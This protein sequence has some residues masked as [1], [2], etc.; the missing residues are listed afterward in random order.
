[1]GRRNMG[2]GVNRNGDGKAEGKMDDQ[3]ASRIRHRD[4]S[5][6]ISHATPKKEEAECSNT[7]RH[8]SPQHGSTQH[9]SSIHC[10]FFPSPM[11][12]DRLIQSKRIRHCFSPNENIA[13]LSVSI[14]L[15]RG[16]QIQWVSCSQ[17][18]LQYENSKS[19]WVS[20][21]ED[22]SSANSEPPPEMRR[23]A[24]LENSSHV[25]VSGP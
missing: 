1:M 6:P 3:N 13:P 10:L 22:R 24:H 19:R 18:L 5:Y 20:C 21:S 7:F 12:L 23:D 17:I 14:R 25:L 16:Y 2:Q 11:P 8:I 15:A 9:T 4:I